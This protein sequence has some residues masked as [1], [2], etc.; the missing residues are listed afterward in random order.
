MIGIEP[1]RFDLNC[2][3][4]PLIHPR[5]DNILSCHLFNCILQHFIN[6]YVVLV[7]IFKRIN[8]VCHEFGHDQHMAL[9]SELDIKVSNNSLMK[10][11][12]YLCSGMV[13]IAA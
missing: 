11:L 1:V 6:D 2:L 3:F 13:I 10:W 5:L 12:A 4:Y 9:C 7:C 8:Y